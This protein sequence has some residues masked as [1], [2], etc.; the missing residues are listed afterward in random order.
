MIEANADCEHHRR[1]YQRV[2]FEYAGE[3]LVYSLM[4]SAINSH[5]LRNANNIV[6]I[7]HA[8]YLYTHCQIQLR[9]N[10]DIGEI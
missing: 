4:G 8:R 9:R 10:A 5:P 1:G 2:S 7:K 3:Y 6:L